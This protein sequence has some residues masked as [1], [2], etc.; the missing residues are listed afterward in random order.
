MLEIQAVTVYCSS[1]EVVA[2]AYKEAA[3]DFGGR[4]ARSGRSLVYGGG[5]VGLMGAMA[6][7]CRGAGGYVVGVITERLRDAEQLDDECDEKIIVATMRERKAILE[8][9][10][11]AMVILPGGLGTLE[12]FFEILVGRLLGEH[13]KPIV[14]VNTPDPAHPEQAG[15]YEPMLDMINHMIEEKFAKAGVHELFTICQTPAEA[16]AA[17]DAHTPSKEDVDRTHLMP[18][19]PSGARKLT[20]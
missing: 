17:L 18:T 8:S 14:I 15:Y 11:D 20:P 9:R 4:L 16:I 1:S 6:R 3:T 12:E 7:G 5:S 2:P 13:D 10:G 19:P